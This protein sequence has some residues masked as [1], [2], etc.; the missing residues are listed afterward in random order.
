MEI[1]RG[2]M[3]STAA[4]DDNNLI[5][6]G[7]NPNDMAIAANYLIEQ[8]GG[9]VIVADGQILYFLP[10]PVAGICSDETCETIAQKKRKLTLY[11]LNLD[12]IYFQ[13]L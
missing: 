1:K 12:V 3:A 10:L 7:V 11:V 5:V 13:N 6:M 9:Q 2:A 4:P 8:G